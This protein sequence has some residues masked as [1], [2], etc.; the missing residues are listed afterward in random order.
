MHKYLTL[1]NIDIFI[2]NN[3]PHRL[4]SDISDFKDSGQ[5]F[6]KN[7]GIVGLLQLHDYQKTA[8]EI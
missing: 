7:L 4:L 8:F 5:C 2:N 3:T 1:D 6:S